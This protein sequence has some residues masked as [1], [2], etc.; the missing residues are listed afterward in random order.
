[1][2]ENMKCDRRRFL[3]TTTMI[4]AA[5][6]F[7]MIESARPSRCQHAQLR[8]CHC[9]HKSICRFDFFSLGEASN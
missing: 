7:G 2:S 9:D 8:E 1:M 4:I 5:P 6:E 3:G